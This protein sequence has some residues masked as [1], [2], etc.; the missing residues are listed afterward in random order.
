MK[1]RN[2]VL[3]APAAL[4]VACGSDETPTATP[5]PSA[6]QTGSAISYTAFEELQGAQT[7]QS[8]CAVL[9][10]TDDPASPAAEG[11]F[12]FAE[13][14]G[15]EFDLSDD[16][17]T[18][19]ITGD[20]LDLVF[21]PADLRDNGDD[22]IILYQRQIASGFIQTFALTDPDLDD[23]VGDDDAEFLRLT[24]LQVERS[25]DRVKNYTCVIGVPIDAADTLPSDS[26]S[27]DDLE[28]FGV[29]YRTEAGSV[30]VE[31]LLD[32]TEAEVEID[33]AQGRLRVTLDLEG[34]FSSNNA[35]TGDGD[36]FGIFTADIPFNGDPR[37][38]AGPLLDTDQ[39]EVGEF[40]GVFFGPE[41]GEL[42]IV[43]SADSTDE[44]GL[45]IS[46]IGAVIE[47]RDDD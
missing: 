10:V 40:T 34:E 15:L 8:A 43:F 7:F 26:F 22:D 19:T 42:G 31:Y 41:G 17:Q 38:F 36:E 23:G 1:P 27:F 13:A 45:P 4:L 21:G 37:D 6:T 3:V 47:D 28:G 29:L 35:G 11:V 2:L 12:S 18:W 46:F 39:N 20:T 5:T 32:D 44:S 9:D 30:V 16:Q 14:A 24:G 33:R 25:D